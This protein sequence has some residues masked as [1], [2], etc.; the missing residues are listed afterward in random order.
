MMSTSQHDIVSYFSF[1]FF[2]FHTSF[3]LCFSVF[4]E[5]MLRMNFERL[6]DV[7]WLSPTRVLSQ[8]LKIYP[9]L[10]SPPPSR[11]SEGNLTITFV[12]LLWVS[13]FASNDYIYSYVILI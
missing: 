9:S 11:E 10:L 7:M 12:K 8:K 2:S 1:T 6:C 3:F 13:K 5:T 4:L